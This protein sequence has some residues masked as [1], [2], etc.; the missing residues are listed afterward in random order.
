MWG[1]TPAPTSAFPTAEGTAPP[2]AALAHPLPGT[3]SC[4]GWAAGEAR[5]R[6]PG[7]PGCR[8]REQSAVRAQQVLDWVSEDFRSLLRRK[9]PL[10]CPSC[11]GCPAQ[12]HS[13]RCWGG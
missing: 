8:W 12:G 10:A 6:G 5:R 1:E 3:A 13:R 9:K 11:P 7:R 4:C 2:S